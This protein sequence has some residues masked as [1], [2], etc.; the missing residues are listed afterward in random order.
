MIPWCAKV[1]SVLSAVTSCPPPSPAV[2]TK[3]PAY[4]P[5]RAPDAQR[6]PVWSQ[7][8]YNE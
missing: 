1:E 3:I 8:D 5:A 4:L 6:P 2:D 7:K